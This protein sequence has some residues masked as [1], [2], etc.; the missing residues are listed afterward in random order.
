MCKWLRTLLAGALIIAVAPAAP[1]DDDDD[2]NEGGTY[3]ALGDSVA[4]GTQ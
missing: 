3:L 4:A 1:A 2:D